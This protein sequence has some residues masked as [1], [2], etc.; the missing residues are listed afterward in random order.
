MAAGIGSRGAGVERRKEEGPQTTITIV[1]E[2]KDSIILS[3]FCYVQ[4]DSPNDLPFVHFI[5]NSITI[6]ECKIFNCIAMSTYCS[7]SDR[8]RTV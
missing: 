2:W 7:S 8:P 1:N 5:V 4:Y 6:N 3:L